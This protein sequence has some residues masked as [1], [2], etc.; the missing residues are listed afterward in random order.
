MVWRKKECAERAIAMEENGS[1]W[2]MGR[3][4]RRDES[5]SRSMGPTH[6][7]DR[8]RCSKRVRPIRIDRIS[9][10]GRVRPIRNGQFDV[11]TMGLTHRIRP[12]WVNWD[13]SPPSI[14]PDQV[15]LDGSDPS[16]SSEFGPPDGCDPSFPPRTITA[17]PSP[18]SCSRPPRWFSRSERS[19]LV[20]G[21]R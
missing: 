2:A 13:G 1:S 3:S 19:P 9:Y 14:R 21:V 11:C 18:P 8:I 5:C 6:R 17:F 7:I 15:I 10:S 12:N 16:G 20:F 4:L